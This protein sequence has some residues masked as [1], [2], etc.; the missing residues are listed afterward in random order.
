MEK[1]TVSPGDV[2]VQIQ[3]GSTQ[4]PQKTKAQLKAERREKQGQ[5]SSKSEI[6]LL[7]CQSLWS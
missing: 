6:S 4:Q 7:M 3:N 2:K 1:E 5:Y